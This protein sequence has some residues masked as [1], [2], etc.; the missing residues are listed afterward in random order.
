MNDLSTS[1]T[2]LSAMITPAVLI[3]AS[4]SLILA[5]SQRLGRVIERARKLT[6]ELREHAQKQAG[7]Q[8]DQLLTEERRVL[9]AQLNRAAKRA[10]FLQYAMTCLYITL[11]IFVATSVA[12]AI[13]AV[14]GLSYT[15]IP[16]AFGIA[17]IALLFYA[18]L[19]LIGESRVA[20]SAVDEEMKFALYISQAQVQP[21]HKSIKQE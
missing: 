21:T 18:S 17:G 19:L 1:L 2:V 6:S 9:F 13:V 20:L 16:L 3:L 12:I 7:N 14:L 10:R 15:W 5:T 4:G 8:D 11:S